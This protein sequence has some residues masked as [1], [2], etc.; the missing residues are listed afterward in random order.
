[1]AL[2]RY[3]LNDA[4]SSVDKASNVC[5]LHDTVAGLLQWLRTHGYREHWLAEEAA[6]VV[7]SSRDHA[8]RLARGDD[9]GSREN[10][11]E[12]EPCFSQFSLREFSLNDHLGR[13][14][15]GY[16]E[17]EYYP[18][19]RHSAPGAKDHWEG[20]QRRPRYDTYRPRG[21]CYRPRYD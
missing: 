12:A 3:Y 20:Q 6:A 17:G 1:M 14:S 2:G 8:E 7:Q 13:G 4:D 19:R 5:S 11:G 16:A 10:Q 15:Q 21:D 18:P 9:Q